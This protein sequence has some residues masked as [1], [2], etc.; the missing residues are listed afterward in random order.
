M[1]CGLN[2]HQVSEIFSS[3]CGLSKHSASICLLT[4]FAACLVGRVTL[5]ILFLPSQVIIVQIGG[6]AFQTKELTADQWLWSVF[7]GVGC[8]LWGQVSQH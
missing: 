8:L 1:F 5:R 2:C 3:V 4:Y 7:L 6:L